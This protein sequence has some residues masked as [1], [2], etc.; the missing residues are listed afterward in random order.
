[1]GTKRGDFVTGRKLRLAWTEGPTAGKAYDH[2]FHENGT[3]DFNAAGSASTGRD[4]GKQDGPAFQA[5]MVDE[6]VCLFSYL[7]SSGYTLTVALNLPERT[8]V[9][10]ASNDKT[11]TPVRGTFEVLA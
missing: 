7:S 9:G 11:W 6:D 2:V 1:M 8:A 3:V 4:G 10:F 5:F